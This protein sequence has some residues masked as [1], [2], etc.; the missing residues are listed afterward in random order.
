MHLRQLRDRVI[1]KD[2]ITKR[3]CLLLIIAMPFLSSVLWIGASFLPGGGNIIKHGPDTQKFVAITFDDGP[4]PATLEILEILDRYEVKATFFVC[5]ANVERYPD[6]AASIVDKG[7]QIANH[8]QSHSNYLKLYPPYRVVNDYKKAESAIY[9]ATGVEPRFY[10]APSGR[11]SPWMR[12]ALRREGLQLVGWNDLSRDWEDPGKDIIID[13][14]TRNVRSG[15]IIVLHDG[16][17]LIEN[18]DRS[19]LIQVLPT[20]IENLQSQGY[21]LVT[22]AEM[23]GE[24]PYF[25]QAPCQ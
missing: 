13:Q 22:V 2:R 3:G 15:S 17:R 11:T 21:Q 20:I 12:W 10:R 8:S 5:G 14:I 1:L 18:P 25:L 6:I 24:D 16:H 23:L 4:S 19:Q 9:E 7:C